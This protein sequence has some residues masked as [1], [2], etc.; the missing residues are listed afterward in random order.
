MESQRR[1]WSSLKPRPP[2]PG[3]R[4]AHWRLNFFGVTEVRGGEMIPEVNRAIPK[5]A[6]PEETEL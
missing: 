1:A 3:K 4:R 6:S 5:W 2:S